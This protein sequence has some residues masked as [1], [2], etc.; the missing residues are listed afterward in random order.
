MSPKRR[1]RLLAALTFAGLGAVVWSLR[2]RMLRRSE[3][4]FARHY[5][6]GSGAGE[7]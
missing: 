4:E 3:Q 1:R 6:G 7:R 5:G 2:A